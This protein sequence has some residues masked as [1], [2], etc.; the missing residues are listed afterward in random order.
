M[1][2]T[3]IFRRA[4]RACT[5]DISADRNIWLQSALRSLA[6][7]CDYMEHSSLSDRMR[8]AIV[9]D[10]METSLKRSTTKDVS[11]AKNVDPKYDDDY[12][13]DVINTNNNLLKPQ[14]Y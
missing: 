10:H 7:V 12:D 4:Q 3:A 5:F 9:C 1:L 14:A 2:F 13:D 11:Y 8:S 6:I